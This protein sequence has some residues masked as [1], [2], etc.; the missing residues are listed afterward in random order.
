MYYYLFF[1]FY[2]EHHCFFFFFFLFN[3]TATTEI[4]TLSL[5]DALPICPD[6]P[7]AHPTAAARRAGIPGRPA[8]ASGPA[9]PSPAIASRFGAPM[10]QTPSPSPGTG[11]QSDASPAGARA[12]VAVLAPAAPC[13]WWRT[14]RLWT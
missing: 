8:P 14:A 6:A 10:S 2:S 4:Y 9:L 12:G 3:D 5:H 1:Q 7:A 11:D 13:P